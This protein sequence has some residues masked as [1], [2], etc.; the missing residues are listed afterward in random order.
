MA[1]SRA[2]FR[3]I[4][5]HH[6]WWRSSFVALCVLTCCSLGCRTFCPRSL[7]QNVVDARQASLVGLDAMQ[8]GR[9]DEAERIFTNAVKACPVD[10]RARGC[11]AETLWRRGACEQA[12]AHMQEA[13]KLSGDDPQ[14]LVQLGEM[15]LAMGHLEEAARCA[16]QATAKNC[17]LS[18]A[19]ALKGDVDV[20]RGRLDDA[21]A[22][23]HRAVAYNAH[24]PRVQ[25]A[26]SSIYQRQERPQRALST[27]ETLAE[28]FPPGEIPANVYAAQGKCLKQLGRHQ[29]AVEMLAQ[30][31]I[32]GTPSADLLVELADAQFQAGDAIA[33]NSTLDSAL[34][35]DPGHSYGLQLKS[36]LETRQNSALTARIGNRPLR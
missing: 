8:Q 35:Q 33:A 16:E 36:S 20:A 10:E 23:Y 25:L 15:H 28:Q 6:A 21:L 11:Y 34:V 27:L 19:W 14:R 9:W 7:T 12:V 3:A 24:Q 32:Q 17:R 29:D 31:V 26:M 13:V 22:T 2:Y 5:V 4:T 18:G 30:A 1:F